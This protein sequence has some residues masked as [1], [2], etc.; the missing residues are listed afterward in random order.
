[1]PPLPSSNQ[2]LTLPDPLPL[3]HIL[4]HIHPPRRRQRPPLARRPDT[5][6]GL[7]AQHGPER[8]LPQRDIAAHLP[9]RVIG[10]Q[11]PRLLV[12]DVRLQVL[13]EPA[14]GDG[15]AGGG[16][17]GRVVQ[18]VADEVDGV[19]E[20]WRDRVGRVDGDVVSAA[21]GGAGRETEGFG[22]GGGVGE[23]EDEVVGV[24]GVVVGEEA[25]EGVVDE[26]VV[27]GG[28]DGWGWGE[29]A[30]EAGRERRSV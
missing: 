27:E 12:Q 20:G 13:V 26:A 8:R 16:G 30:V 22:E 18:G 2:P 14:L 11:E 10:P 24:V 29:G 6:P 15:G 25:G 23:E 19:E 9:Q 7:T 5:L 3:P 21:A 1:M 4:K 28:G 17:G